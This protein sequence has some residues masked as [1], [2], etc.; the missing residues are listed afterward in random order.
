MTEEEKA[1]K[2]FDA[3]FQDVQGNEKA[4]EVARQIVEKYKKKKKE[5]GGK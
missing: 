1:K 5:Q 4:I 2:R 3:V